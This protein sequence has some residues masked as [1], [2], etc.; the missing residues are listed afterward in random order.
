[1]F[2]REG[3]LAAPP[4]ASWPF[5]NLNLNIMN[6]RQHLWELTHVEQGPADRIIAE[7]IQRWLSRRTSAV[8]RS[9]LAAPWGCGEV[10]LARSFILQIKD[11]ALAVDH[12]CRTA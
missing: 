4:G 8:A 6:V 11:V 1:M 9:L 12:F 7:M 3:L 10:Q 5:A 2:W